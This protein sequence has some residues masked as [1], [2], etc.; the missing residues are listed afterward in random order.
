MSVTTHPKRK[1]KLWKLA[2]W[3]VGGLM[4]L[5]AALVAALVFITPFQ[6]W[7]ATRLLTDSVVHGELAGAPTRTV[8]QPVRIVQVRMRDGVELSTQLYLPVGAGPWPVIVSRDP[9]SFAQYLFC[10]VY[11]QYGYACVNQEVRGRGRSQGVWY[12]FTND[13][14]DGL[15]LLA[16]VTKQ[17]WQ[18]GRLALVG[19]SYLGVVQWAVAGDLPPEVKTFV[20]TVA[21]GDVYQLTYHNGM[22][23]EGITGAWLHSQ[24]L[25]PLSQLS[26]AGQWRKAVAGHFPAQGVDPREFGRTWKSYH[27]YLIHPDRDDAYWQ[28][29]EYVALR[30]AHLN[31]HV[32]VL[33]ID[34]ANDFF[35]PGALTTYDELPT[36]DQSVFMI[37]PGNHGGAPDPQIVGSYRTSYADTLAW[38][39]HYLRGAPLPDRLRPGVNVF[40]HGENSWRHFARWPQPAARSMTFH[41]DH[42]GAAQPCD[43]GSLSPEAP[44]SPQSATYAYDPRNPV[45]TRGGY[46]ELI[47]DAVAEQGADLCGRADVLS[48]ASAPL[49]SGALIDGGMRVRLTVASDAADTAFSVKV[50][51]HFADGRVLNIRDDISTLSMRNGATHRQAYAPGAQ[52]EIVFDVA[53]IL[54][55]LHP[56]SR[57]RLD[58]SSSSAPAFFPHPNRAGLWSEIADPVVAHQTLYGG[59]VEI[60]LD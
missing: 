2:L 11:V 19:G 47:S 28:S 6:D 34:F 54:W 44:P 15:D 10:K 25:S 29:P 13:R 31:V 53:P 7:T 4:A 18:N 17:P 36:R 42:L 30:Q 56:G 38:F 12:P 37:G 45:P 16:W 24:F 1:L 27:D 55:R 48:F 43:G 21:H 33:M 57:L 9:Y 32:P 59:S 52:V 26:A 8:S 20:P 14:E 40:V 58:I 35:L 46:F 60:P 49:R 41:L 50:S 5:L 22:F 3:F 39:D 51:E 23:D